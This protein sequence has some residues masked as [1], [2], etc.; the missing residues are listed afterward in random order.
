MIPCNVCSTDEDAPLDR[1]DDSYD[2]DLVS[3]DLM[4]KML[5]QQLPSNTTNTENTDLDRDYSLA[6][7][8]SLQMK[9]LAGAQGDSCKQYLC[10]TN[11]YD[12]DENE[13]DSCYYHSSGL[14]M[15]VLKVVVLNRFE[16][17]TA[18]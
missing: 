1:S 6:L 9:L 3:R 8:N 7:S 12:G 10:C 17:G 15:T 18:L 5:Q 16:D 13:M 11:V 14:M 2:A 4:M